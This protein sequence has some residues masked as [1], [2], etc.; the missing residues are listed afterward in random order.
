MRRVSA[1]KPKARFLQFVLLHIELKPT[2][3]DN[4]V[5][6]LSNTTLQMTSAQQWTVATALTLAVVA[7]CGCGGGSR[8]GGSTT[9]AIATLSPSNIMVG[10]PLGTLLVTGSNFKSDALI[11][12][13]GQ[14]VS[15]FMLDPHTLEGEV[16]PTFD[17]TVATHEITVQQSTGTSNAVSMAVY[18]PQQGPFVMNAIPGF[19]VGT[20]SNPNWIAVADIDGDGFADVLMPNDVPN[21]SGG[22]AILKGRSDGSLA[23]PAILSMVTPYAL[24][25]GDVDGD[26]IPDLVSVTQGGAGISVV[27]VFHGDGHG[28]FQQTASSQVQYLGNPVFA[29]LADLDGDGLPDLVLS[30]EQ[31]TQGSGNLEWL[32]NTGGGNFSFAATLATMNG[33]T[34]FSIGDLNGDG[35]PDIVYSTMPSQTGPFVVHTL[36][37]QG[38]GQ[39]SD[40]PTPGLNG[41]GGLTNIID[42]N[43]DGIPDLVV[44]TVQSTGVLQLYS[45]AGKGDGSFQQVSSVTI[46]PP[47][48]KVYQLVVG[49]FDHDGFPDL[50]GI[51]GE[52]EP[53]HILYLFGDGHGDFTPQQVVGPM[54]VGIAEGDIN[55]DGLPDVIVPD[56]FSFVSVALGQTGRKFPSA[57]AL[58]P[59]LATTAY[60]GDISGDG[61]LDI[62]I[63]GLPG[64]IS[65]TVFKNEGN[66]S[67][68]F[69]AN[70][71]PTSFMVADLTGRGV[72]DLI[73]ISSSGLVIWPNNGTFGFSSSPVTLPPI[74]GPIMVADMDGDGHPDIVGSGQIF[75]GNGAYQFTPV[76]TPNVFPGPY[77]IGDFNGDGRL[78]IAVGG[79]TLLNE[80]NRTFK[81]V[82]SEALPLVN[83]AVAAVADFNGDGQDD[84]AISGPG[85]QTI[86]IYY[87]QSDGTF[88]LSTELD[89]GEYVAG[90][91]AGDFN[92]DGHIDVAAGLML[93]QQGVILFNNGNGQFSRSFFAS[94]ADTV[95][96][97]AADLNHNG[98]ADLILTNFQLDYRPPNVDVVLHK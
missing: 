94:G 27:T 72:V 15:T 50:A 37:N 16:S 92:G 6:L 68:Q 54:G 47:G 28:N 39:F 51:D 55:G 83:G 5:S 3:L 32:R 36:L 86:G 69:A 75:Y 42:F 22:I 1:E 17:N 88:L 60:V 52:T 57:L 96:M 59:Q 14:A 40:S 43:L 48:Y 80:G 30:A 71:D 24:L 77:L 19:L 31:G 87:G 11:Q 49:D 4:I 84:V 56:R 26:G 98:K 70:T 10:V 7:F 82:T 2:F 66:D 73:G 63:G 45:F 64:T 35:K 67:F 78:D 97:T 38:S 20:E 79:A 25:V 9:P 61:L 33:D 29:Y 85:D 53:S 34:Y 91:A 8:G 76:A 65:G 74:N 93:A 89:T 95:A 21:G 12:I 13:D 58:T 46:S 81:V 44:Q 90:L 62:F 41:I 18:A 23:P